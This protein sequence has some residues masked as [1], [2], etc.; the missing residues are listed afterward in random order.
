MREAR[1]TVV[2][3]EVGTVTLRPLLFAIGI[4]LV[5]PASIACACRW[6]TAAGNTFGNAYALRPPGPL[7]VGVNSSPRKPVPSVLPIGRVTTRLVWIS[8]HRPGTA[9]LGSVVPSAS[10]AAA[11]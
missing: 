4:G 11:L 8:P 7:D 2:R 5:L 6:K 10:S 3:F 1:E 9:R